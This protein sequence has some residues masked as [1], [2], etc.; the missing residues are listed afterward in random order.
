MLCSLQHATNQ[1]ET[2]D[3]STA[4]ETR[5]DV[6]PST[7]AIAGMY[8][9]V[10]IVESSG[11]ADSVQFLI[12]LFIACEFGCYVAIRQVVNAKEWLMACQLGAL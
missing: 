8:T 11:Y 2:R 5:V 10:H 1:A 7:V 12:T 6:Y 9:F 4:Q 3:R